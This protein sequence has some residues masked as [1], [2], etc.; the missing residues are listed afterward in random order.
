MAKKTASKRHGSRD[1]S[2][3]IKRQF[4]SSVDDVKDISY[5]YEEEHIDDGEPSSVNEQDQSTASAAAQPTDAAPIAAP[6][7]TSTESSAGL[8]LQVADTPLNAADI[9]LA[10]TAQKLKKGFDQVPTEKSIRELSGGEYVSSS[11][12]FRLNYMFQENLR[13]KMSSWEISALS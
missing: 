6:P 3:L 9:V 2:Q 13:S 11:R 12:A 5:H 4:L 7:P 8:A 1:K 10:L